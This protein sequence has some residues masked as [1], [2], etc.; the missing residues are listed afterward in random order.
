MWV[1][2]DVGVNVCGC[3]CGCGFECVCGWLGWVCA[4]A[5]EYVHTRVCG[6]ACECVCCEVGGI[7]FQTVPHYV[8]RGPWLMLA[9]S[10]LAAESSF[11]ALFPD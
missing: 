10:S 11:S 4:R 3:G 6:C 9:V 8:T 7:Y 1:D 2:V 5:R